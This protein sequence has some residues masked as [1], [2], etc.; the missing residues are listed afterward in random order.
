MAG[1]IMG[2]GIMK[3]DTTM[4]GMTIIPTITMKIITITIITMMTTIMK[5][6]ENTIAAATEVQEAA[7]E[8]VAITIK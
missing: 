7:A 1:C 6:V 4:A 3:M 8:A 5:G 2:M